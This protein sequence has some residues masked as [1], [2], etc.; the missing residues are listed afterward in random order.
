MVHWCFEHVT[1]KLG[2]WRV[3]KLVPHLPFSKYLE[4]RFRIDHRGWHQPCHIPTMTGDGFNTTYKNGD[5]SGM[6][7]YWLY[8]TIVINTCG[9]YGTYFLG[10]LYRTSMLK[11]R[12]PL[13]VWCL[14]CKLI[15]TSTARCNPNVFLRLQY[16][17]ISAT[18]GMEHAM[19]SPNVWIASPLKTC[20]ENNWIVCASITLYYI[21]H[22]IFCY[23]TLY[24]IT[25]H[26]IYIILDFITLHYIILHYI[27]LH[28]ITFLCIYICNYIIIMYIY[29]LETLTSFMLSFNFPECMFQSWTTF[30]C[31]C[32]DLWT[33]CSNKHGIL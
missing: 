5:A 22:I 18:N 13:L 24:Y 28:C 17:T 33:L 1:M 31:L 20:A 9:N 21:Y 25:L 30:S 12:I 10:L 16:L 11:I 15:T 6:V 14:Q 23:I 8:R 32:K 7:D 4:D 27:I 26:I 3:K 29:M 19:W 2:A